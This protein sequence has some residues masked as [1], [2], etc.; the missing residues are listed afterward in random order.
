MK[1]LG[2]YQLLILSWAIFP[3]GVSL[4]NGTFYYLRN[5]AHNSFL[6]VKS[7]AEFCVS[8]GTVE[9]SILLNE[10]S[11]AYRWLY[12]Q[13]N[14]GGVNLDIMQ[15]EGDNLK[16]NEVTMKPLDSGQCTMAYQEL[17]VVQ[18]PGNVYKIQ[19]EYS[20]YRCMISNGPETRIGWTDCDTVS[21]NQE[22]EFIQ[23]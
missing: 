10:T 16:N 5:V 14:G 22:W 18:F 19:G 8:I 23:V 20:S 17:F 12:L 2:F 9:T 3:Y 1:N 6:H 21:Q 13:I 7:G 15:L 4:E 11:V